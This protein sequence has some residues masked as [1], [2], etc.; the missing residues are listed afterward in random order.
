[1]IRFISVVLIAACL[2]ALPA[3]RQGASTPMIEIQGQDTEEGTITFNFSIDEPGWLVLHPV[4]AGGEVDTSTVLKKTQIQ[5]A[6]EYADI[7]MTA[8]EPIGEDLTIVAE[9]YY[10]DPADGK[11]TNADPPVEVNGAVVETSFTIPGV[12]PYIEIT[13]NV[14]NNNITIK[15]LTYQ[16]GLLLVLCPATPEGEPDTSATIKVYKIP[17]AGPFSITITMPGTLDEGDTLF[18]LLH[19]DNPDDELFTYVPGGDEDLP[20]EVDGEAVMDS[21]VVNG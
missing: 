4:T 20:V 14:T 7:E 15:G 13:Q 17:Y 18:A 11:F 12:P 5:D 9:L 19:Y 6:G 3:C 10:D 8:P 21:I 1:M 16:A 2:L